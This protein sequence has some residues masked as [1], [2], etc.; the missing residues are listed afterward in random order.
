[1]P[2]AE[3]FAEKPATRG[4]FSATAVSILVSG[5]RDRQNSPSV[6]GAKNS[7]PGA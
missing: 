2:L 3:I 1:L 7:V 4:I 6:S 5:A